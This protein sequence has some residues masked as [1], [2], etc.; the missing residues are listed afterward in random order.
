MTQ[1][2]W[3]MASTSNIDPKYRVTLGHIEGLPNI[4][5]V[6][7]DAC[8]VWCLDN[9]VFSGKFDLNKWFEQ[10]ERLLEWKSKCLFISIPDVVGDAA[11][12]LKQF[13]RYRR[14]A[15]HWPAAFVSQDGIKDHERR[16]PWDDFDVLF[17][18]GSDRH[19]R[20]RVG[21]WIRVEAK[22]RGKW[23][24][25]GRVN[26]VFGITKRFW[27]ADS[28]DGTNL[29]RCPSNAAIFHRAVLYNR[30]LKQ[31]KGLFHD[32]HS[33]VLSGDYS[34]QFV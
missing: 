31:Q 22:K 9:S 8:R 2:G 11:A 21:G 29:S 26:S 14:M 7:L 24:H 34:S 13:S 30:N 3:Y 25:I 19:K 28:W 33:N 23:V 6:A 20:G 18:G 27:T 17:V 32:L 4:R 12:T 10:M 5:P 16:I 1:S 15:K